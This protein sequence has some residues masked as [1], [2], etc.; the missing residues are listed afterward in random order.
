MLITIPRWALARHAIALSGA[1]LAAK[2]SRSHSW[3]VFEVR[4]TPAVYCTCAREQCW[5]ESVEPRSVCHV[6]HGHAHRQAPRGHARSPLAALRP[7]ATRSTF[8]SLVRQLRTHSPS[9]AARNAPARPHFTPATRS[10]ACHALTGPRR[11]SSTRRLSWT[12]R[13][14]SAHRPFSTRRPFSASRAPYDPGAASASA[15]GAGGRLADSSVCDSPTRPSPHVS[16][17]RPSP[18]RDASVRLRCSFVTCR[19]YAQAVLGPLAGGECMGAIVAVGDVGDVERR[20][21]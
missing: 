6:R 2:R 11:L 20:R 13:P 21:A 17:A 12:R 19:T 4:R 5:I 15:L 8:K 14:S 10:P 3:R 9:I 16:P 1:S 18:A 7:A